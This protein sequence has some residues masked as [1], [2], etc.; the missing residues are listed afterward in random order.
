MHEDEVSRLQPHEVALLRDGPR[1]AVTVVLVA[2]H[3]RGLVEPDRPGTLRAVTADP[4]AVTDAREPP[5][6]PLGAAVLTAL[7]RTAA[8]RKVARDPDVRLALA[9]MRVPLAGAGLLTYPMLSPNRAARRGLRALRDA[10]P[11]PAHRR[12]LTEDDTLLAVALHGEAALRALVPR[13]ALRAGLTPRARVA[14]P[15][16][17]RH[18]PRGGDS[19]SVVR[20]YWDGS[21]GTGGD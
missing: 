6:A 2:L 11:L 13:F 14:G 17:V 4:T 1:A 5:L 19:T 21:G 16:L 15:Y 18:P 9:L 12:D 20:H 7:R 10:H 3:L 8:S